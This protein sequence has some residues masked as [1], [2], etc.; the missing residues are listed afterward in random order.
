MMGLEP[1][2]F[3]TTIQQRPTFKNINTGNQDFKLIKY[4]KKVFVLVFSF[5][6][7]FY[8]DSLEVLPSSVIF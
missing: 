8:Q 6:L 2:T 7:E 3:G 1:T 4:Y 5:L